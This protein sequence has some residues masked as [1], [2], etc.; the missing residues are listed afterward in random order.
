MSA[1]E[2]KDYSPKNPSEWISLA[3]RGAFVGVGGILPGVSGGVLCV[4]F[5]IYKPLMEVLA[6]PMKGL[7]KHFQMF[8][9]FLLGGA[10]GFV[11][12]AGLIG[13][14]FEEES[15]LVVSGFVGLILGVFPALFR[16]AGQEGRSKASWIALLVS[17]L[18]L[19]TFFMTLELT[20]NIS[21]TPNAGWFFFSGI[22]FGGGIVVPGMSS[23]SLLMFLGLYGPMTAGIG[24]FDFAVLIPT[25]LGVVASILLF[26]RVVQKL[27]QNH[28]AVTFHCIV[29]FVIASTAPIIP[30]N[31]TSWLEFG[32]CLGTGVAC[33]IFAYGMDKWGTKIKPQEKN[34]SDQ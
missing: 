19:T 30:R 25:G 23:S 22:M 1:E 18:S 3:V 14:L 2:T 27:F 4:A 21:I 32:I 7:K 8:I 33:C 6:N 29:G 24:D 34:T 31:F 13:K 15:N 5:G 9:P 16:E 28:Y 10:V 11:A 26:A 17:T 12:L 20:Q